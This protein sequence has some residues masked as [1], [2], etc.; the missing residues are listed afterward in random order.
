MSIDYNTKSKYCNSIKEVWEQF[1]SKKINPME[2][3][4]VLSFGK[5][6]DYNLHFQRNKT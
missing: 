6:K 5:K 3:I 1:H 4:R 2:S